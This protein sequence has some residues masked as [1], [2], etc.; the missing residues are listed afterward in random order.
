[1]EDMHYT[2]MARGW[3]E[4]ISRWWLGP[5]PPAGLPKCGPCEVFGHGHVS[6]PR[7]LGCIAQGQVHRTI[8]RPDQVPATICGLVASWG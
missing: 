8:S 5:L 2:A 4:P 7:T 1:M 3:F 6:L